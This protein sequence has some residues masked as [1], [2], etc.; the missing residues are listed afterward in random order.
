[1]EESATLQMRVL[2]PTTQTYES[3]ACEYSCLVLVLDSLR[4]GF[5][6]SPRWKQHRTDTGFFWRTW[7][8]RQIAVYVC[9]QRKYAKAEVEHKAQNGL[10]Q[11]R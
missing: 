11:Q 10:I 1:M 2:L 6:Q 4:R 3:K 5:S 8:E 9:H 7:R